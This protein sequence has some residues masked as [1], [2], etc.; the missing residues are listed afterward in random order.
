MK[1]IMAFLFVGL[2]LCGC[3]HH[4]TEAQSQVIGTWISSQGIGK[5]SYNPDGSFLSDWDYNTSHSN[6]YKGTWQI[7]GDILTMTPTN[8]LGSKP[9]EAVGNIDSYKIDQLDERALVCRDISNTNT[10]LEFTRE[11]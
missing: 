3:S 9:H 2:L 10:L 6:I 7:A 1:V 11:K 5:I 8:I 4:R